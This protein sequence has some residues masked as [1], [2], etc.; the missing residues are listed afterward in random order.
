MSKLRIIRRYNAYYQGWCLVFGEHRANY[1]EHR[2]VNWLIGEERM[3]LIL[4]PSLRK[5]LARALLRRQDEV[6]ELVLTETSLSVGEWDY[7]FSE[8]HD[9]DHLRLFREFMNGGGELHMFL[10]SH[11][12]YPPKTR[13]LTF[14]RRKPLAIM[15]KEMQ[16]LNLISG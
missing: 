10:S 8:R 2:A 11:F 9:L 12:C 6:P 3:G 13:I 15:H 16:P 4:A 14:A 7:H 1:D 5:R